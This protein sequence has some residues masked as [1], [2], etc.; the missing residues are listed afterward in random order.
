MARRSPFPN[1]S[2]L[3]VYDRDN[4]G[5]LLARPVTWKGDKAPPPIYLAPE[6]GKRF[7][8]PAI[9]IGDRVLARIN[10]QKDGTFEARVMKRI[11]A[12]VHKILGVVRA[13]GRG[14]RVHPVDRRSK[15]D[16][17][18]GKGELN[19]AR[20][21]ELVVVELLPTRGYGPKMGRVIERLCDVTEPS[22]VS[23]IAIHAHNI[24][25]DF[26][27][28]VMS[29]AKK[30]KPAPMGKR[31]DL[32]D[33]PFITIDPGDARDHDDAIH[34]EH[35]KTPE[36]KGGFIVRVAIADV[37]HYIRTDQALDVEALKRGNSAYFPDRVVPM[38]PERISNDLCSLREGQDRPCLAVEMVFD[39]SGRKKK[40]KFLRGMMRSA[41][42]LSY[43]EAQSAADG[44]PSARAEP[45]VDTVIKPL[46]QAYAALAKARD[47]RGPLDLDLP[48]RKIELNKDGKIKSISVRI[49]L[50]AHRLVEECMIQANVCA[51]ESLEA[52]KLPLIYRVHETPSEEKL[53]SLRDFLK[54]L[55]MNFAAGTTIRPQHFNSILHA[56]RD[57]EYAHLISDVVLRSQSQAVYSPDNQGHFGLN[58]RRYAHFTSPIRRYADLIVHRALVRAHDFG[59]DGL[60][61]DQAEK[62]G[63]IA[64][65]IS[66]HERRAMAAERDSV[67]R[68]LAAYMHERL[69]AEFEGRISGVTRFG[70]FVRLAGSG[71][72]GL[73]PISALGNE[74]FFHDEAAHALIGERSG[75]GY[76]LGDVVRVRI[77]EAAP[78]TG[79]LRLEMLTD[80]AP[81]KSS[82]SGKGQ[83]SKKQRA[84]E[85]HGRKRPEGSKGAKRG[86]KRGAKKGRAK[87]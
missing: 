48:E 6:R 60:T 58:L 18:I 39:K 19:G 51:A 68:Y 69:G 55:D 49:R 34:A 12:S 8:G 56:V 41:A 29:A 20:E 82:K 14:M 2:V 23:L 84:L 79:G 57:T 80:P 10:L 7:D 37:A 24:P 44:A 46:Y 45:F 83:K 86:A 76:R 9:G 5:E 54:T 77:M 31:T 16:I 26:P 81:V 36:N 59:P 85:S 66:N 75:A 71:A 53:K 25:M 43:E 64:E 70:L 61:D 15:N 4:D 63:A 30:A 74:Y 13:E 52:A 3:D 1:V 17:L 21:G 87:R 73:V 47:A 40:H 38:L 67:D 28:A 27:D 11:G 33:I 78:I 35:D 65:A 50:D 32:R 62:L 42:K 22:A 72:D